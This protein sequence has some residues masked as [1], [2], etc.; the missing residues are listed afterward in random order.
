MVTPKEGTITKLKQ[1]EVVLLSQLVK[2]CENMH[3][4]C[5]NWQILWQLA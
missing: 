4:F 5:F 2:T 3:R 1:R